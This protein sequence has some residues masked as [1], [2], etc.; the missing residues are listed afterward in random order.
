MRLTV[1]VSRQQSFANGCVQVQS[2]SPVPDGGLDVITH[3]PIVFDGCRERKPNLHGRAPQLISGQSYCKLS[4]RLAAS[5]RAGP[6]APTT[7][8]PSHVWSCHLR[9]SRVPAS[10]VALLRAACP[11]PRYLGLRPRASQRGFPSLAE[12]PDLLIGSILGSSVDYLDR[13]TTRGIGDREFA[14]A[15]AVYCNE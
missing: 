8:P 5:S 15:A 11:G 10:P 4:D 12:L 6:C 9:R 13:R 14:A 3:D 7:E 2:R 1:L